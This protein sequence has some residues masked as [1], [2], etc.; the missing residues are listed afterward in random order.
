MTIQQLIEKL[1]ELDPNTVVF[2]DGYEG[3]Y[4]D[5]SIDSVEDFALNVNTDW[6]Y[7]PHSLL[8]TAPVNADY[9]TVK[10]V[11]LRRI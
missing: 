2:V 1:Q 7:G 6:Y 9:E 3:G 8:S 4:A 5:V 11:C 10:G